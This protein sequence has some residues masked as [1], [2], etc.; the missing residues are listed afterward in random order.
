MRQ[1]ASTG[2]DPYNCVM[3][4]ASALYG[5]SHGGANEAALKMLE[6]I[7]SI[8]NIPEFIEQ[9]KAK[10]R[11]L[12]GFGHRVYKSYDPRAKILRRIA[13]QVFQV[14]GRNPLIDVAKELER[15]ALSDEYFIKRNLYPNVDFYSGLIYKA[16]GFPVTFFW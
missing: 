3:G 8:D 4:A 5:P 10:K 16:M 1:L 7:G 15:I 13:D 14:M 2:M 6:E 9:V 11:K 12:M